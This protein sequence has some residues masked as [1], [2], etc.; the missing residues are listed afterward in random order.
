MSGGAVNNTVRFRRK[1]RPWPTQPQKPH[2]KPPA[3]WPLV[4]LIVVSGILY[5]ASILR[6]HDEDGIDTRSSAGSGNARFTLCRRANQQNCVV[7][8]D[9]IHFGGEI[10]RIAD[11]NAPEVHEAKCD[12][13]AA[14]GR[15]ATQRLV[16]LL[17]EG[18]FDLEYAG[19][20]EHDKYGRDLRIVSRN[21]RSLGDMLVSE[22]LAE[23]WTGSKRNWCN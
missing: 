19:R 18:P 22:G 6:Q 9:T 4:A 11:I 2:R 5:G 13:E 3:W 15:R 1:L 8:G 17:N 10:I 16:A 12:A 23:R 7:D 20:R 21:G 14:L